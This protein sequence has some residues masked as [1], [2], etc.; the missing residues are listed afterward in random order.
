MSQN[1]VVTVCELNDQP[2]LFEQDWQRLLNHVKENGSQLVLLP[3]MPFSAWFAIPRQFDAISWQNAVTSH[4]NWAA[5][6][7]ELSPALVASSQPVND[8]D[9]RLNQ[10]YIYEDQ[11]LRPAHQKYYLPNEEGF[12]EAEWYQRGDGDFSVINSRKINMGFLLCT[13]LWFMQCARSYGQ[14]GAH[15]ILSPRASGRNTVEKWLVA[16]KAAAM[17]SGAY[18][19]SSNHCDP[20][21]DFGGTGWVIDPDGKILAKTT[22]K[23]PI[24]SVEID[25]DK[26]I[27][28]K[29]TYPRYVLD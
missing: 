22:P 28:A 25:L 13:E 12:W 16:G 17:I 26:A 15:L 18:S 6:L 14:Q 2:A 27:E 20:E 3:E 4:Q 21:A 11:H 8:N 29:K 10:A 23:N 9:K 24:I 19:L 7:K 5:R 1:L